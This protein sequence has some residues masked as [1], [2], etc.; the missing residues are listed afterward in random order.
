MST[1]IRD[2]PQWFGAE[3]A[4]NHA[5]HVIDFYTHWWR[6]SRSKGW[7]HAA[8]YCDHSAIEY[9]RISVFGGEL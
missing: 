8:D 3:Q 1:L 9:A 4:P 5:R 7:A 2:N 6:F